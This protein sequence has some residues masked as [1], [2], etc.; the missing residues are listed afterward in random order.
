VSA[1]YPAPRRSAAARW[2]CFCRSPWS[3]GKLIAWEELAD[4][5][6]E[7]AILLSVGESRANSAASAPAVAVSRVITH[8]KV[9]QITP[10]PH[11]IAASV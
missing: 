9:W 6:A 5:L 10:T 8:H 1:L 11:S 4:E 2:A 3:G 7:Q